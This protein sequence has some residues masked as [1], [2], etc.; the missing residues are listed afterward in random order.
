MLVLTASIVF[1]LAFEVA[2]QDRDRPMADHRQASKGLDHVEGHA[3]TVRF[4]RKVRMRLPRHS[5][6]GGELH[7]VV[8]VYAV[9]FRCALSSAARRSAA[10]TRGHPSRA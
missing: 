3:T 9:G 1:L 6:P 7:I 8:P 2:K 4:E 10:I 5:L